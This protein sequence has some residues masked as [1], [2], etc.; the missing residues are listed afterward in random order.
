MRG[1]HI[2]RR[3]RIGTRAGLHPAARGPRVATNT[4]RTRARRYAYWHHLRLHDARLRGDPPRMAE[5][6]HRQRSLL[7]R[8]QLAQLRHSSSTDQGL[9]RKQQ[10]LG[11]SG[12]TG[13][14]QRKPQLATGAHRQARLS[15]CQCHSESICAPCLDPHGSRL[16]RKQH[17]DRSCSWPDRQVGTGHPDGS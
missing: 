12:C 2:Q 14:G 9:C 3:E 10:F 6:A 11:R 1:S 4:R 17:C 13:S 8:L 7:L 16:G 15:T 5:L